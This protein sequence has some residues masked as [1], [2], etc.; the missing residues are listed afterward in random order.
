MV[1]KQM[2]AHKYTKVSYVINNVFL[3]HV[4]GTRYFNTPMCIC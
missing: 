3:L 2:K 1:I 4:Y